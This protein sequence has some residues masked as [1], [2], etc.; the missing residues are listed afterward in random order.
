MEQQGKSLNTVILILTLV[1]TGSLLV[2]AAGALVE[3]LIPTYFWY[4]AIAGMLVLSVIWVVMALMLVARLW[5]R[6][7]H[8]KHPHDGGMT[9]SLT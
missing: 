9:G 2:A 6:W 7:Y 4:L 8:R 1:T 5:A 3:S